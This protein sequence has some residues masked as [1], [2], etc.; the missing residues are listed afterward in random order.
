MSGISSRDLHDYTGFGPI[1]YPHLHSFGFDFAPLSKVDESGFHGP[2]YMHTSTG[3][4]TTGSGTWNETQTSISWI[5]R[6]MQTLMSAACL[7]VAPEADPKRRSRCMDSNRAKHRNTPKTLQAS[8]AAKA[9][10]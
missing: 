8:K 3:S 1:M 2:S 7:W 4:S 10:L 9:A 5:N 6:A